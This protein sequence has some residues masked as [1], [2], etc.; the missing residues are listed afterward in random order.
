MEKLCFLGNL[1][2]KVNLSYI[3]KTKLECLKRF[4]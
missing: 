2:Q 4:S 1:I 3:K